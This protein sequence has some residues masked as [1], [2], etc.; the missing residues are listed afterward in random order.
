[1]ITEG[2]IRKAFDWFKKKVKDVFTKKS[3]TINKK[4]LDIV[5]MKSLNEKM[6][7]MNLYT[8]VYDNPLGKDD[9]SLRYY[10][11]LP[12]FFPISMT[13]SSKG[14][15]LLH[16]LNIHYLEP[17][18]RKLLIDDLYGVIR[19]GMEM[20]GYDPDVDDYNNLAYS[21]LTKFVGKYLDKL[22]LGMIG[23]SATKKIRIAYRTYA[24]KQIG[25]K[26][27]RIKTS[28]W[29]NAVNLIGPSFKKMSSSEI[30]QDVNILYDKY[31][32]RNWNSLI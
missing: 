30:Y 11:E 25:S 18:A 32:N 29:E 16:G 20:T 17:E 24:L 26:I 9:K 4:S 3:D 21:Q 13:K 12:L 10:D 5:D 23:T 31:K 6:H 15:T 28:E 14:N 22:Y 19:E 7:W 27:K 2:K 8:M 1:M